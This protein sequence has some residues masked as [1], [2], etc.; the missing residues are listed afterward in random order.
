M[1]GLVGILLKR[2]RDEKAH[3]YVLLS[4]KEANKQVSNLS[5]FC[6]RRLCR[7][8]KFTVNKELGRKGLA[9]NRCDGQVDNSWE[10]S[11]FFPE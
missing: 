6:W 9:S 8:Y 1:F 4:T 3:I 10:N 11:D 7:A 5:I 2:S